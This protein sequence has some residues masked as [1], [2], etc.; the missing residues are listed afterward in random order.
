MHTKMQS[1]VHLH[2]FWPRGEK[3]N[4]QSA[5]TVW[6]DSLILLSTDELIEIMGNVGWCKWGKE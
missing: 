4:F 5:H 1:Y 6:E 3:C 2:L